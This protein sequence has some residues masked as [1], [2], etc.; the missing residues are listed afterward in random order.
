[1]Y[2]TD[3]I[4]ETYKQWKTGVV[5]INAGTGTGKTT[6]VVKE[7]NEWAE[8]TGTK[9][10]YL[11]NRSA[12]RSQVVEQAE[13]EEKAKALKDDAPDDD[14]GEE[15][16]DIWTY[17]ALEKKMLYHSEE[18]DAF[19]QQYKYI[20]ADEAHYFMFDA[21]FNHD[22]VVSYDALKALWDQK[23]V[24]YMSAT[25]DYM[26]RQLEN[27]NVVKAEQKYNVDKDTGYVDKVM[28]HCLFG[29]AFY[30]R[31]LE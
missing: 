11:C 6:F 13:A 20:V 26:F 31:T 25:A 3:V 23:I 12:L 24:I 29:S 2:V 4:G 1:M 28:V 10:L 14:I 9:I 7:Q 22:T 16:L 5:L 30:G 15:H 19:L 17:Q 21:Q 27:M 18:L 8:I